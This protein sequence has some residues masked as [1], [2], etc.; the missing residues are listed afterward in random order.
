MIVTFIVGHYVGHFWKNFTDVCTH[1]FNGC[2]NASLSSTKACP[3][4]LD[5]GTQSFLFSHWAMGFKYLLP[6]G[7][8]TIF[9][10]KHMHHEDKWCLSSSF[11]EYDIGEEGGLPP[12][13]HG[14]NGFDTKS[15]VGQQ[16]TESLSTINLRKDN[17]FGVLE[18][19]RRK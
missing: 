15:Y 12:H 17:G 3:Y 6:G 13:W 14:T 10:G 11:T 7:I 2:S 4:C 19:G 8:N 18:D 9:C 16:S 5:F 1:A